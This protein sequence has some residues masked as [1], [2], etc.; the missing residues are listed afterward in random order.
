MQAISIG[1]ET[2]KT[3]E[4]IGVPPAIE[5]NPHTIDGVVEALLSKAS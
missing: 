4:A 5:A 3:L 2:T 1:P